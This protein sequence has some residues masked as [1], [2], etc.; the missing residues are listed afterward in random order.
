MCVRSLD[1]LA[2]RSRNELKDLFSV[3]TE[4]QNIRLFFVRGRQTVIEV[5]V[6]LKSR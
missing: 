6:S 4:L 5:T 3:S 2:C 1:R